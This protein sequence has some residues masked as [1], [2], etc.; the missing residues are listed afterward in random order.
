MEKPAFASLKVRKF[1]LSGMSPVAADF[2]SA[3]SAPV[4][5]ADPPPPPDAFEPDDEPPQPLAT[6]AARARGSAA[7]ARRSVRMSSMVGVRA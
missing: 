1:W 7:R 3:D 2:A 6:A 5:F 4:A